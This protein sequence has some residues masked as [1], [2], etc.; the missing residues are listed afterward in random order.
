MTTFLLKTFIKNYAEPTDPNV[1]AAVGKMA[2][3][4]GIACN[5]LLCL[6]KLAAGLI[7]GS[8]SILADAMNNLSDAVS[9]VMT[10][11]G[12]RLARRPA[13][14]D[15]PFGHARY[16]YLSGLGVAVLILL[17]GVELV[18]ASIGKIISPQRVSVTWMTI[19]IL[20]VSILM[21]LWMSRFFR[22]AGTLI[23]SAALQATSVDSRN[24]VIATGGVL[25]GCI[26]QLAWDVNVDGYVGLAVA[27]FILYSGVQMMQE[28]VSPLL[29]KQADAQ[30]VRELT[31]FLTSHEKILGIH[32]LLI[33]DYGPGQCFAS[34][35]AEISAVENVMDSHEIIDTLEQQV[36][37]RLNVN[38]VI[39]YDPVAL[40]DPEWDKMRSIA[41]KVISEIDPRLSMHDFRLARQMGKTNL[42]FHLEVPYD[43]GHEYGE[44][45]SKIE[46]ALH[47]KGVYYPAEIGFDGKA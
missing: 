5:C 35:H 41:A 26:V 47:A 38:L 4:T 34:V 21:K 17:I 3:I 16:E 9:S 32:D 7:V 12:F 20:V 37:T 18:Q 8:L 25:L 44:L 43:M 42:V 19:G 28:T 22:A 1:R 10:L 13:D 27:L 2:G 40:D 14:A 15:H 36:R 45:Q 31:D 6:I 33:H 24:D 46:Q 39:H 11:L 30:L 29:G 23:S